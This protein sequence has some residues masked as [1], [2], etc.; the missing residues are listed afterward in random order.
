MYAT[1]GTKARL[2]TALL[3]IRLA[4]GGQASIL[5][6]PEAQAIRSERDPR[7]LLRRFARD[8]A[9]MSERVRPVSEVLRTAK[10][11]KRQMAA[12]RKEME[13]YRLEY[14]RTIVGWLADLATLRVPADRAA[15]V[16]WPWPAPTSGACYATSRAG[17]P[18]NTPAGSKTPSPPPCWPPGDRHRTRS[19]RRAHGDDQVVKPETRV[20]THNFHSGAT[21][22]GISGSDLPPSL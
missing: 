8:Y 22:P 17:P 13:A 20:V 3:D 14:M 9:A 1:F 16:V 10:A 11:V 7:R 12:V 18:R 5:D 21:P 6:R 19:W 4:P 15:Q 2:L